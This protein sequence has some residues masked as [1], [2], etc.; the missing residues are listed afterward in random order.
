MDLKETAYAVWFW[1]FTNAHW[2]FFIYLN[3]QGVCRFWFRQPDPLLELPD[4]SLHLLSDEWRSLLPHV[5]ICPSQNIRRCGLQPILSFQCAAEGLAAQLALVF[6]CFRAHWPGGKAAMISVVKI[7]SVASQASQVVW[8][9][10]KIQALFSW[11]DKLSVSEVFHWE[12]WD[13]M[14]SNQA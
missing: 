10:W 3:Q 4:V 13:E 1:N 11:H 2:P 6:H 5:V 9:E 8:E 7:K 14:F 12:R